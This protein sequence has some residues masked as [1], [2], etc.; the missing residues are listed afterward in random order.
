MTVHALTGYLPEEEEEVRKGVIDK[1]DILD[2]L[3]DEFRVTRTGY[4]IPGEAQG[5]GS[6]FVFVEDPSKMKEGRKHPGSWHELDLVYFVM[7]DREG[8]PLGY[9]QVDYP[10][11]DKI[12]TKE[13]ME[14][15]EAFANIATIAIENS[16]TLKA[17]ER[18]REEV[19]TYLDLLT[20]DVGN[21]VNPVNAYLEMVIATTSLT[22]VQHKYISSALEASRSMTHL[23]RNVRKSSQLLEMDKVELVPVNLS[24][25]LR[26]SASDARSAFLAKQID[27]KLRLPPQDLWVLADGFLDEVVYN[28]LTNAIKYDDHE[29]VEIDVITEM[30]ELE[31]RD[32]ACVRVTDHGHGI[33]DDMKEKI[34]SKEFRRIKQDR[35]QGQKIK[36]AGM[37]LSIVKSLIDRYGGKIWVENRVPGDPSRGSVFSILVPKA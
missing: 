19:R 12:P 36:G 9:L 32:F 16:T 1:A 14:A 27:I 7:H 26:Q 35:G 5:D 30:T 28:V 4:F 15:M 17:T 13:T 10:L 25:A 37:G 3:K 18:A 21:L 31:G 8:A 33:P 22:E 24:R 20:H 2:D 11:D 6:N 29:H 34:F 23:I